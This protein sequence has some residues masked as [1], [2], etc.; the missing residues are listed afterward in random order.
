[1]L[2]VTLAFPAVG[3]CQAISRGHARRLIRQVLHQELGPSEKLSLRIAPLRRSNWRGVVPWAVDAGFG[4]RRPY[5]TIDLL[6]DR[7]PKGHTRVVI[8]GIV[9]P[10]ATAPLPLRDK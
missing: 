2:V 6:K 7:G 1:M 3:W 9:S 4:D 8:A 10:Q 5:G